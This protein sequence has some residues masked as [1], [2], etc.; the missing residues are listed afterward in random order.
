V[1]HRK[2]DHF[3]GCQ[4]VGDEVRVVRDNDF[5]GSGAAAGMSQHGGFA[6][7]LCDLYYFVRHLLRG[8]RIFCSDIFFDSQY[9]YR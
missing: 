6:Q 2:D 1:Y 3:F 5:A 9:V 7:I 8:Y 4:P